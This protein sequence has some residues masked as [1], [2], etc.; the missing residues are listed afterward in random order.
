MWFPNYSQDD[1][2]TLENVQLHGFGDQKFQ[3]ILD[4]GSNSNSDLNQDGS[5]NILDVVLLV[6]I[7][8]D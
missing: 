1:Y 3:V 4:S 6:G 8:L 2:W 5:S 7:I